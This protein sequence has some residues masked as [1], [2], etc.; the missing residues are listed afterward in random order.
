VSHPEVYSAE[1]FLAKNELEKAAERSRLDDILMSSRDIIASDE[2]AEMVI[3]E[4]LPAD[5]FTML[6]SNR[7]AGKTVVMMDM[8]CRLAADMDWHDMPMRKD[9][10]AVYICGEYPIGARE[11]FR[12]WCIK[13]PD[14]VLPPDRFLFFGGTCD[15]LSADSVKTWAEYIVKEL[16]GRRAVIFIDTWQKATA[17]GDQSD[18]AMMQTAVA[19]AEAMGRSVRGP[20]VF[21]AHPPKNSKEKAPLT[22]MGSSVIENGTAGIWHLSD[23]GG[24]RH[25][26]VDRI[27]GKGQGNYEE[28]TFNEIDLKRKDPYFGIPLTAVVPERVGGSTTA[29]SASDNQRDDIKRLAWAEAIRDLLNIEMERDPEAAKSFALKM[30]AKKIHELPRSHTI[31]SKL[32]EVTREP[33]IGALQIQ[34]RFKELYG[35]GGPITMDT[36]TLVMHTISYRFQFDVQP[37]NEL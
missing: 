23:E 5:G 2:Y 37:S 13:N 10:A 30:F 3:P 31:R 8:A 1:E 19:H 32:E 7:G 16:N 25:L 34:N 17:M 29:G 35:R 20:V 33:L 4:W 12:A 14:K 15:L 36:N 27:K 28:F 22:V 6:I 24:I 9:F 26:S 11:M 18:N 21:A